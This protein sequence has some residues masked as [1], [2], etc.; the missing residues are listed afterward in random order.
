MKRKEKTWS[1]G[2]LSD[3]GLGDAS[4]LLDIVVVRIIFA[5][6]LMVAA[7]FI[8]PFGLS[9][10][11]TAGVGLLSALCIIFF[12][13]R[14]RKASLKRLIGAAIGSLLG[15]IGASL[16]SS[17]LT[18]T[19]FDPRSLSFIKLFVLF[20]MVYVGLVVGANKGDLLNLSAFGGRPGVVAGARPITIRG[21]RHRRHVSLN[22]SEVTKQRARLDSRATSSWM[23]LLRSS[24]LL[25]RARGT[26]PGP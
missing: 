19:S 4:Y 24:S 7:F 6:T 16:I 17:L 18:D 11:Y 14:L 5:V 13:H 21:A 12:E 1:L 20:L 22:S 15:I 23:S 9:G 10:F 2:G 8:R 25:S 26:D 3:A